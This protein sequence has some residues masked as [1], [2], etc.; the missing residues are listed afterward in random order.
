MPTSSPPPVPRT[1][2]GLAPR[3]SAHCRISSWSIRGRLLAELRDPEFL[4]DDLREEAELRVGPVL[5]R[6]PLAVVFDRDCPACDLLLVDFDRLEPD[7]LDALRL[8]LPRALDF[9]LAPVDRELLLLR[10]LRLEL[11]G[12]LVLLTYLLRCFS[13]RNR[14][15]AKIN[16]SEFYLKSDWGRCLALQRHQTLLKYLF[17][18]A[19]FSLQLFRCCGLCRRQP[20]GQY[21]VR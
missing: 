9:L 14:M 17:G 2:A 11:D 8:L 21:A 19:A 12:M 20:C 15:P 13:T 6:D 10:L 1:H 16:S 5:L 7:R 3:S 18:P 4:E